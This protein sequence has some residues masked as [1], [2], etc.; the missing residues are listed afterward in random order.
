M[1]RREHGA[2]RAAHEDAKSHAGGAAPFG[3]GALMPA[4]E[5][6]KL[7]VKSLTEA[8]TVGAS[9]FPPKSAWATKLSAAPRASAFCQGNQSAIKLETNSRASA[10]NN[11]NTLTTDTSFSR[12]GWAAERSQSN[13]V[14]WAKALA[15]F[16]PSHCRATAP[17]IQESKVSRKKIMSR[18][19]A[20]RIR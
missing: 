18:K 13:I 16:L 19:N 8:K 1:N 5:K 9:D 7:N 15:D 3:R 17:E 12:V 2:S 20:R 4:S 6:Q 14:Q 11:P 10:G